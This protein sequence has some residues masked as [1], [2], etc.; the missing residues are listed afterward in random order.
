MG[1]SVPDESKV[2]WVLSNQF[3]ESPGEIG[4]QAFLLFLR[5]GI[6]LNRGE[7]AQANDNQDEERKASCGGAYVRKWI[8]GGRKTIWEGSGGCIQ[9]RSTN[10]QCQS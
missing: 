2:D 5:K 6:G 1:D 3:G 8:A 7:E 4:L 9:L 10:F